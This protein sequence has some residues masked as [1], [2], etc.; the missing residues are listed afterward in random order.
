MIWAQQDQSAYINF[1]QIIDEFVSLPFNINKFKHQYYTGPLD[2]RIQYFD[3][4]TFDE[5]IVLK[6]SQTSD[7]RP[8]MTTNLTLST[9][10]PDTI[11]HFNYQNE[12]LVEDLQI[13]PQQHQDK[14]P[15]LFQQQP[16]VLNLKNVFLEPQETL[17]DNRI[18]DKTPPENSSVDNQSRVQTVVSNTFIFPIRSFTEQDTYDTTQGSSIL[19]MTNTILTP[20]YN[21][22]YK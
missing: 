21:H 13:Q 8:D 16:D 20:R 11:I 18:S 22:H 19:S 17:T 14:T 15:G 7:S 10:I 3:I 12:A 4:I 9:K 1:P 2:H 5:N 6:Q